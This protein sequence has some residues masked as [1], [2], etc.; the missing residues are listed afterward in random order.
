MAKKGKQ[1]TTEMDEDEE[2]LQTLIAQ[3]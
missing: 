2:D 3:I 1:I